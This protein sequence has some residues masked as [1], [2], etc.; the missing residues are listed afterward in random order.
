MSAVN[1]LLNRTVEA[2][3]SAGYKVDNINYRIVD[4]TPDYIHPEKGI[5]V[6]E[7]WRR[8]HSHEPNVTVTIYVFQKC[9]KSSNRVVGKVKVPKDASDKVI[10]SRVTKIIEMYEGV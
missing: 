2:I 1:E 9:G 10:S 4:W 3:R 7:T 6:E 8:N 5:G